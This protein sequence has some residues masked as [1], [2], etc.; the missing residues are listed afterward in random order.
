MT[1]FMIYIYLT[2]AKFTT[3]GLVISVAGFL[4]AIV[5]LAVSFGDKLSKKTVGC[6][7]K[8]TIGFGIPFALFFVLRICV[9]TEADMIKIF[10]IP[11]VASPE[12]YE[13]AKETTPNLLKALNKM[14]QDY[15]TE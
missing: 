12:T 10:G 3:V 13:V 6:W 1:P 2:F 15:T 5:G 4:L 11:L 8:I 7:K 14:A 9:P